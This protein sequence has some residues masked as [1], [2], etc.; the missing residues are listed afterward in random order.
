MNN[1]SNVSRSVSKKKKIPTAL[2]HS[3]DDKLEIDWN[4]GKFVLFKRFSLLFSCILIFFLKFLSIFFFIWKSLFS[5]IFFFAIDRFLLMLPS[6]DFFSQ[7]WFTF[8]FPQRKPF[9]IEIH[10][11]S[12]IVNVFL[13]RKI[14][15]KKSNNIRIQPISVSVVCS[16]WNMRLCIVHGN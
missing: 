13:T 11:S 1:F 6:I 3:T 9:S 15:R 16:I 7:L 14:A 10:I 5:A 8:Y 4:D 12:I 2:P